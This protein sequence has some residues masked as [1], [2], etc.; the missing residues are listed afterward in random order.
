MSIELVRQ[1]NDW[2]CGV[3]CL[4]MIT[5]QS[6]DQVLSDLNNDVDRISSMTK[7]WEGNGL[8]ETVIELYLIEKEFWL[9]KRYKI[10]YDQNIPP[11]ENTDSWP[12]P[13]FAPDGHIASV[14]Q[15]S[16][17]VHYVVLNTDNVV[18]DPMRGGTYKL[19]DW[20]IIYHI[21]GCKKY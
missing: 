15:P 4:A 7:E 19:W 17:R 16:G 18:L 20:N 11:W 3:A 21:I 12:P 9:Q 5:N 14:Q 8:S 10:H 2:G 1:K 13:P 6:Y